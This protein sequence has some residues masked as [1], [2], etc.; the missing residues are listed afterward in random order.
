MRQLMMKHINFVALA[1]LSIIC[2]A[3]LAGGAAC[4]STNILYQ[5]K[6]S[7]QRFM[8][9]FE[10]NGYVFVAGEVQ[11]RAYD[12]RNPD[13]ILSYPAP[14]FFIPTFAPVGDYIYYNEIETLI[15]YDIS[16]M[17]NI[18]FASSQ[19]I[20]GFYQI[21]FGHEN[22]FYATIGTSLYA[23]D[24]SDPLNPIQTENFVSDFSNAQ[25]FTIEQDAIALAVRDDGSVDTIDLSSPLA[26]SRIDIQQLPEG[27]GRDGNVGY[28]EGRLYALSQTNQLM[29][30]SVSP[31]GSLDLESTLDLQFSANELSIFN[32]RIWISSDLR[33]TMLSI[34]PQTGI[35]EVTTTLSIGD[36]P[37]QG[38][39]GTTIF[40]RLIPA[41]FDFLPSSFN[42][43][44]YDTRQTTSPLILWESQETYNNSILTDDRMYLANAD[45]Q[46]IDIYQLNP[47]SA[48][49][50]LGSYQTPPGHFNVLAETDSML[51]VHDRDPSSILI[52]DV[53]NP[54][55]P[56]LVNNWEFPPNLIPN[57]FPFLNP[58][59]I[60]FEG[61]LS[62]IVSDS[63]VA[64]FD[65]SN[66]LSPALLGSMTFAG[67]VHTISSN[68]NGL[69]MVLE[70]L[71]DA[72][73]IDA[74]NPAS[75]S[76]ESTISSF[77]EEWS[78]S[79]FGLHGDYAYL[80]RLSFVNPP[81]LNI[82]NISDP[83]NPTSN[84]HIDSTRYALNEDRMIQINDTD[85]NPAISM[86]NLETI[87]HREFLYDFEF[88][89]S[90]IL[91]MEL[92]E[93]FALIT[94]ENDGTHLV[95]LSEDCIDC[96][97]DF[98]SDSQRSIEDADLFLSLYHA[99]DP[100]AD[101]S[102]DG[103]LNF[104]DISLFIEGLYQS[105]E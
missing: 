85:L 77:A 47:E 70:G 52:I 20:D 25:T 50:M 26:P 88:P 17:S 34:N 68:P 81:R 61:H 73:I 8:S 86:Y 9:A 89:T 48:P 60:S 22:A 54:Q 27:V 97:S 10:K 94:L 43:N 84:G 31:T 45:T 30:Y 78:S 32:N 74:S 65:F 29:T 98:N 104:F 19:P 83:T 62:Y 36:L 12:T 58:Q 7:D 51:Y 21:L 102:N 95:N 53:S 75:M 105:C 49:T 37:I 35:P 38:V 80:L 76:V 5:S 63:I 44:F 28:Y 2:N 56:S 90:E 93:S 64:V 4:N 1:I 11:S 72:H 57:P 42:V 33:S 99:S 79:R 6:F 3:S 39:N 14:G 24:I 59:S 100:I 16:D 66:P 92:N 41:E 15:I 69:L 23:F 13:K 67:N 71:R 46:S 55:A 18:H 101:L 103:I 96:P 40:Q 87:S 91:R 82:Y